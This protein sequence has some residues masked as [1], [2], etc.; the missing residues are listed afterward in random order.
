M[1]AEVLGLK[2]P[3]GDG[4]ISDPRPRI[5]LTSNCPRLSDRTQRTFTMDKEKDPWR[6]PYISTKPISW[7]P[8]LPCSCPL[9]LIRS[10]PSYSLNNLRSPAWAASSWNSSCAVLCRQR[11]M[12]TLLLDNASRK[13]SRYAKYLAHDGKDLAEIDK[14]HGDSIQKRNPHEY[15]RRSRRGIKHPGID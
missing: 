15:T 13:E 12:R 3:N 8:S 2:M 1:Y 5:C 7:Q 6:R 10:L 4:F 9:H 14:S 11:I